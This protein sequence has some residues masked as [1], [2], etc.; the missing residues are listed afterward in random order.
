MKKIL[1]S[2]LVAGAGVLSAQVF[3][4]E[5]SEGFF[6]GDING[7]NDEWQSTPDGFGGFAAGQNIT[8]AYSTDGTQSLLTSFV[9]EYPTQN[10]PIIGG[11]Y[12][13]ETPLPFYG[14]GLTLSADFYG[15][16]WSTEVPTSDFSIALVDADA[17]FFVTYIVF[18]YDGS[19]YFVGDDGMGTGQ[20]HPTTGTWTANTWHNIRLDYD[21]LE[22]S[23]YLDDELIS[24]GLP[25]SGGA[26]H[27]T[28]IRFAHDNYGGDG[29]Y[30]NIRINDTASVNDIAAVKSVSTVYPNPATDVVNIKLAEDFQTSKTKVI[31]SNMA[32]QS[33]ASFSSVN[34]VN[35]AKLPAGVYV[36]TITDGV[37][38]E[39]KKLIKK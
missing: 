17:G 4:F 14:T 13:P 16:T 15:T 10:G 3:S 35:V 8:D 19:V 39:T 18:S 7:Q 5:Q 6:P 36:L 32:G 28:Q 34:D 9:D 2:L 37:K 20:V 31:V 26:Q 33:V 27:V 29:Y 22:M 1:F 25:F 30:D 23:L 38:T 21:G 12:I 11:W 24:T